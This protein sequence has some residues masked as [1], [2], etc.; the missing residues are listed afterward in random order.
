M[1]AL[2]ES[3]LAI[4]RDWVT[5]KIGKKR[6]I[7]KT[8]WTN[9][10]PTASF[11]AQT[12]TLAESAENFDFV[13]VVVNKWSATT[14]ATVGTKEWILDYVFARNGDVSESVS[15]SGESTN[16]VGKRQFYVNGTTVQFAAGYY[17]AATNNA[18]HVPLYVF[19]LNLNSDVKANVGMA[20]VLWE[21]ASP[22]SQ[23]AAQ[24]ITLIDAAA[25]YDFVVLYSKFTNDAD[26]SLVPT[27]L[28][29]DADYP[30]FTIPIATS[31]N[32]GGGRSGSFI[33]SNNGSQIQFGSGSFN[34]ST[35]RNDI[36]I[37]YKILGVNL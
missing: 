37:P 11:A 27:V 35:T 36:L 1:G 18:D 22:T 26:Q 8:L 3:G 4:L 5:D 14:Y 19:G 29:Y 21:N 32:Y 2:D 7:M 17:N 15:V 13:L 20:T 10:S 28:K 24:T 33:T 16:R 9:P 31:G 12:I 30:G 23:F 25:N 34:K 6:A